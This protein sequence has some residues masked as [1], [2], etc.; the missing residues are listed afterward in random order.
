FVPFSAVLG[1]VPEL[2]KIV[3]AAADRKKL[4]A[5]R[6]ILFVDEIHR[7]NRAQQDAFLPHVEGG[8]IVLIGAT[9]ENPSFNVNGALLSRVRVLRLEPLSDADICSLLLRAVSDPDRGL[10]AT[11][12]Q[13]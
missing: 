12:L 9:T 8:T 10:G 6:T 13:I 4:Q 1:G 3:Q 7:F 2:R 5:K 11:R